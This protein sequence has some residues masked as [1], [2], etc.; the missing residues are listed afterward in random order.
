MSEPLV[1]AIMLTK[2][3]P[4]MAARAVRAFEAQTY[5]R[6]RLMVLDAAL[7]GRAGKSIGYLRNEALTEACVHFEPD[8]FIHWDDDDVSH[9]SRIAEQVAHLQ[10]S[11]ADVVGY[12]EIIFWRMDLARSHGKIVDGGPGQAWNWKN[13]QGTAGSSF[14][15]WRKTW[16]QKPFPDQPRP[17]CV[18]GEDYSFVQGLNFAAVSGIPRTRHQ[19]ACERFKARTIFENCVDC[20]RTQREHAEHGE[21]RLVASIHGGNTSSYD[22]EGMIARGSREWRRAPEFDNYARKVMVI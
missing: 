6:K 8:I 10:S 17:G 12:K 18:T 21:P 16:E 3:R 9:P 19:R 5:E 4:Q 7:P 15:Y 1:A 11:G 13:A 22:L 14:A 2:D 20:D